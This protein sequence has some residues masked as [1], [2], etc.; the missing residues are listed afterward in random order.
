MN[1]LPF[2]PRVAAI[3]RLGI[4]S[5][6]AGVLFYFGFNYIDQ[7]RKE[8]TVERRESRSMVQK[9]SDVIAAN[10]LA[11]DRLTGALNNQETAVHDLAERVLALEKKVPADMGRTTRR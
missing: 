10:T 7:D 9:L 4:A 2:G 6:A 3:D 1:S 8:R 11:L 5:V